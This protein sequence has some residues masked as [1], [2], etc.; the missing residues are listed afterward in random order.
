MFILWFSV[1]FWFPF[2]SKRNHVQR[3]S[4]SLATL[5]A[6]K[7]AEREGEAEEVARIKARGAEARRQTQA[8]RNLNRIC[9]WGNVHVQRDNS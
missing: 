9:G 2:L 8:V 3:L 7:T 5:K 6:T 4:E 1:F